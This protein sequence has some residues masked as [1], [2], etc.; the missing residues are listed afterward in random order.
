MENSSS[1]SSNYTFRRWPM[2]RQLKHILI[3]YRKISLI[4]LLILVGFGRFIHNH[5]VSAYMKNSEMEK[6]IASGAAPGVQNFLSTSSP[7]LIEKMAERKKVFSDRK[8]LAERQ[9]K[10]LTKDNPLYKP[11]DETLKFDILW[12]PHY[13]VRIFVTCVVKKML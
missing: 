8:Q 7:E 2:Y 9:C 6:N 10:N 3:D 5:S 12:D 4:I 13:Q 11:R 1:N